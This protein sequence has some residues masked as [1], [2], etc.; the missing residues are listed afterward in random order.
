[1]KPKHERLDKIIV[2]KGLASTRARAQAMI[3]AGNVLVNEVPIHKPGTAIPA[4]S[5][6]R[7]REPEIKYVSRAA[8]KIKKAGLRKFFSKTE[9]ERF[10]RLMSVQINSPGK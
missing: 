9:F 8:L 7:L 4:D 5:V 3:I 2:E 6:I 1:L 10:L